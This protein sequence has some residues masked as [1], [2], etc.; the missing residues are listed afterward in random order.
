MLS[1]SLGRGSGALGSVYLPIDFTNTSD[2]TCTLYG[3]PG[4]SA[5]AFGQQVGVPAERDLTITPQRVS[6]QP[7]QQATA[8]LRIANAHNYPEATCQLVQASAIRVY[9]PN[10]YNALV[11]PHEFSACSADQTFMT[12]RPVSTG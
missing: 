4:V 10:S 12:I 2:I 9:P 3:F 11:V 8:T 5:L 1:L 7:G 6:L